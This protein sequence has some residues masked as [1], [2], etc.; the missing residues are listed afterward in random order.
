MPAAAHRRI[1]RRRE[2]S[3]PGRPLLSNTSTGLKGKQA[4]KGADLPLALSVRVCLSVSLSIYPPHVPGHLPVS[5]CICGRSCFAEV[6]RGW[7]PAVKPPPRRGACVCTS[8]VETIPMP[9]VFFSCRVT[10][11]DTREESW[12]IQDLQEYLGYNCKA[13]SLRV[14]FLSCVLRPRLH[15]GHRV[16]MPFLA[17]LFFPIR[18][19]SVFTSI[20]EL[21][22]TV[23]S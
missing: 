5:L 3:T 1:P 4:D 7:T 8:A 6:S 10:S 15:G 19:L 16:R 12:L 22:S 18:R 20:Q 14:F 23:P 2:V 17:C 11:G 21:Y 13:S 9:T